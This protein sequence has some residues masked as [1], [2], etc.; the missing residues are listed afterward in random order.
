[1]HRIL[2]VSALTIVAFAVV[3]VAVPGVAS[4]EPYPWEQP[5]A[6]VGDSEFVPKAQIEYEE[7]LALESSSR[8]HVAAFTPKAQIEYEER[9]AAQSDSG[10]SRRQQAEVTPP[11]EGAE[12]GDAAAGIGDSPWLLYAF[13]GVGLLG[14]VSAL[15]AYRVGSLRSA[16]QLQDMVDRLPA[17]ADELVAGLPR[18]HMLE[19]TGTSRGA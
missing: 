5:P 8:S 2:G 13:V 9:I 18:E 10:P 19:T 6:A 1:M 15:A 16:G 12:T 17:H 7:R 14:V 4:A 11:A 3:P